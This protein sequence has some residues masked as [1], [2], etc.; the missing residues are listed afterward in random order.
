MAHYVKCPYCGKTFNADTE[1]FIKVSNGRR[2]AHVDCFQKEQAKINK[3]TEL[4]DYINKLYGTEFVS[5]VVQK[6]IKEY[7]SDKYNYTDEG[8][9][10]TLKY[11]YE[12][13]KN[14]VNKAN[15]RI[16]I[17]PFIYEE[18]N[19]YFKNIE[20]ANE[21][22]KKIFE[23]N[24]SFKIETIEVTIP[25]PKRKVRKRNLFSFLDEEESNG[26]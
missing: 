11:W 8:I 25:Q 20:L 26:K 16:S 4:L 1:E 7:K 9:L 3:H 2:Y 12:V 22:N 23:N 13:K 15:G 14:D 24:A 18:A 19:Y 21:R 10:N 5:P 17:V 6:Q